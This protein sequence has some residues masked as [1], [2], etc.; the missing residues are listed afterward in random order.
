MLPF[1][2]AQTLQAE[3]APTPVKPVANEDQGPAGAGFVHAL[4]VAAS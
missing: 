2:S 4:D 3:A 1:T